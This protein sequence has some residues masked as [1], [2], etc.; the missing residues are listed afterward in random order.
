MNCWPCGADRPERNGCN[1]GWKPLQRKFNA[2]GVYGSRRHLQRQSC[3]GIDTV[4]MGRCIGMLEGVALLA[5][6]GIFSRPAGT[7][8]KERMQVIIAYIE[9][10]PQRLHE[11]FRVLAVEAMQ[12]AWPCKK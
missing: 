1:R 5:N 3:R 6:Y 10:R 12:T 2:T 11:D 7:I 4:G 8:I 9:A